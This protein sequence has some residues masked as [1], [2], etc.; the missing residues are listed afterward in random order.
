M[1]HFDTDETDR[2]ARAYFRR[3]DRNGETLMQPNRYDSGFDG[4]VVTLANCNGVLARYRVQPDG[5]LRRLRVK[6]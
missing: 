3:G 5:R 2:A 1:S 4:D 6:G